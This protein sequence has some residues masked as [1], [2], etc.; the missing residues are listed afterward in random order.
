[1][2]WSQMWLRLLNIFKP[3]YQT[4]KSRTANEDFGNGL[5]LY[6]TQEILK[7]NNL[8]LNVINLENA[9]KFYIE[10]N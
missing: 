2:F 5:G 8:K 7:K 3:F 6:I 9:V 4:D 10:F 1:M